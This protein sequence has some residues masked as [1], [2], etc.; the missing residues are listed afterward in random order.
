MNKSKVVESAQKGK[1]TE[2]MVL[3]I[4]VLLI[5][6]TFPKKKKKKPVTCKY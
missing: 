1:T 4:H 5:K 6:K 3:Y 2:T